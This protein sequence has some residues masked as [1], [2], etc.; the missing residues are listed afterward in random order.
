MPTQ[1]LMTTDVEGLT[2][3]IDPL[4][5]DR[6]FAL[7]GRNFVFEAKGPRSYFGSR[8][9]TPV[10]VTDPVD[11]QGIRLR[12]QGGDRTFH[13]FNNGLLEWDESTGAYRHIYVPVD[14][15]GEANRWTIAFLNGIVFLAHPKAPL[16]AYRLGDSRC[17][18]AA[19]LGTAVPD[20][21]LA[22]S[23]SNGRLG[24]LTPESFVWSAPGDGLDYEPR[25]GFAGAQVLSGVVSG[26]PV[27]L[28]SYEGGFLTLTSGGILR[29]EFTGTE[30]VFRHRAIPTDYRPVN[31]LCVV[32]QSDTSTVMFD[33]RGLFATAGSDI[34][35]Y[36]PLFNEF[37]LWYMRENQIDPATSVRLE[38]DE[39]AKQLYVM[40]RPSQFDPR[41][42][43]TFVLYPDLDK[44]GYMSDS[45]YGVLPVN[46]RDS[47]RAGS[48]HGIVD[49]EGFV[50]YF[51]DVSAKESRI[52][53]NPALASA[54]LHESFVQP[55]TT[56]DTRRDCVIG[57]SAARLRVTEE[58]RL[59]TG[60]YTV[61]GLS[62]I[63][64]PLEA[65]DSRL[66][67][68][69]FRPNTAESVHEMTEIQE[70]L[71]RN[72]VDAD[73]TDAFDE[74]IDPV[75]IAQS[76]LRDFGNDSDTLVRGFEEQ[77]YG[78]H[79]LRVMSSMDGES[80]LFNQEP[81]LVTQATAARSYAVR[82]TG[83]FHALEF[84]TENPGDSFHP[85]YIALSFSYGGKAI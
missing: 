75:M 71:I 13:F 19:L 3:A 53:D 32:R 62:P 22:V 54:D 39:F 77:R 46:I 48:F 7:A 40:I 65:M 25:I 41:Y 37:I 34:R 10:P 56:Y 79:G 28:V 59:V 24:L 33:E 9:L 81:L 51:P 50:R 83:M 84:F 17:Y 14:T 58:P 6:V 74:S 57:S 78:N 82:S 12:L 36:S 29:S 21:V 20:T 15:A 66:T 38:W 23:E 60:Y 45:V 64:L 4:A 44:W 35:P 16:L 70:V 18:P 52:K 80:F 5:V 55:I 49:A 72:V 2:P 61:D 42:T 31:S 47:Q 69:W 67:L 27:M 26:R 85:S 11:A 30:I 43:I 63:G 73:T 8:F 76:Y 1:K 68:G